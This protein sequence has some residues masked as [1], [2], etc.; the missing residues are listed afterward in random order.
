MW[1]PAANFDCQSWKILGRSNSS[2]FKSS[3]IQH[4]IR[5]LLRN[6]IVKVLTIP[7][8][9]KLYT[10][11]VSAFKCYKFWRKNNFDL[12]IVF[13]VYS[14][15]WSCFGHVYKPTCHN[16][17]DSY[18]ELH[19][20]IFHYYRDVARHPFLHLW[21]FPPLWALHKLRKIDSRTTTHPKY[22]GSPGPGSLI[23]RNPDAKWQ[24]KVRQNLADP[25][26]LIRFCDDSHFLG[27]EFF[28]KIWFLSNVVLITVK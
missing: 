22:L 17:T 6:R 7:F 21:S 14:D 20:S 15:C 19:F 26:I 3:D 10:N 25:A 24:T 5:K 23:S 8:R 13:W 11:H 4:S 9:W 2:T 1:L 12:D 27:S 28:D 18:T 16:K